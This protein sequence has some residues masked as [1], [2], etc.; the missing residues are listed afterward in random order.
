MNQLKMDGIPEEAVLTGEGIRHEY[1]RM[2]NIKMELQ[3][4]FKMEYLSLMKQSLKKNGLKLRVGQLVLI[5]SDIQKRL[6][7][8]IGRIVEVYQGKD[9]WIRVVKVKTQHGTIIRP[10]QRIYPLEL[11][12]DSGSIPQLYNGS[13]NSNGGFPSGGT[14]EGNGGSNV[15]DAE[16]DEAK[17]DFN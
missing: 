16:E 4:R 5:G 13:F 10:I 1:K 2:M 14:A 8:P 17:E 12:L 15:E 6:D 9:G 7:W 3:R 11:D